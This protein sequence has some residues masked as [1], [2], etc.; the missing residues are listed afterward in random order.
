MRS[1]VLITT[2]G[3]VGISIVIRIIAPVV[4]IAPIRASWFVLGSVTTPDA[5][6]TACAL[7]ELNVFD[8]IVAKV[9]VPRSSSDRPGRS[10]NASGGCK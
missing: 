3:N 10:A 5:A 4:T 2:R 8:A 7:S 6:E 1:R 9:E